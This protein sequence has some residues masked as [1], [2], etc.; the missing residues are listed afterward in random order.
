MQPFDAVTMALFDGHYAGLVLTWKS[1]VAPP[2]PKKRRF[3]V[4]MKMH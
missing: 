1:G 3:E 2:P 4:L